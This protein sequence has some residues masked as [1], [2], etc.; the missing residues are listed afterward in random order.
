MK[1]IGKVLPAV[2]CISMLSAC[3][4]NRPVKEVLLPIRSTTNHIVADSSEALYNIG[5]YYQGKNRYDPAKLYGRCFA[6]GILIRGVNADCGL[7][8]RANLC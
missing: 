4:T 2:C 5:R 6:G 1:F 7:I 3:V 8:T